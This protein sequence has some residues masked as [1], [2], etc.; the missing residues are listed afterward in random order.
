M[1]FKCSKCGHNNEVNL[2]AVLG[3]KT[4]EAK[5]EAARRNESTPPNP[6]SQPLGRPSTWSEAQVTILDLII[7]KYAGRPS[8]AFRAKP[9]WEKLLLQDHNDTALYAKLNDMK[10]QQPVMIA[11][12]LP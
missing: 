6:G 5:A 10:K 1:K 9:E 2:G 3:A 7:K 11:P 12:P 8:I 4:S